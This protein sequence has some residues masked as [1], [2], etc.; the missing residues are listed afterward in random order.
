MAAND[1]SNVGQYQRLVSLDSHT[2][3]IPSLLLK[4]RPSIETQKIK[5]EKQNINILSGREIS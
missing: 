5:D 2:K 1:Y 4:D 3:M